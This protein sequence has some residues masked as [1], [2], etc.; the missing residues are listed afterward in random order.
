MGL[1]HHK[2]ANAF[3]CCN[4]ACFGECTFTGCRDCQNAKGNVVNLASSPQGKL[5]AKAVD[6]K[7]YNN[8]KRLS[9]DFPAA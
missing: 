2:S 9:S 6:G 5:V 3:G 4:K 8:G 7:T 1:V